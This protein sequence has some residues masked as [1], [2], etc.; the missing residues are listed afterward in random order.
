VI[1]I[2]AV[3]LLID[4]LANFIFKSVLVLAAALAVT[5]IYFTLQG[6]RIRLPI[7][8]DLADKAKL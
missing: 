2:V 7:I 1:E 4:D 3:V 5:G 6:K 8:S